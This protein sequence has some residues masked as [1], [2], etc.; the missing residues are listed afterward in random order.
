VNLLRP[1]QINTFESGNAQ[2]EELRALSLI[3]IYCAPRTFAAAMYN[4]L[5]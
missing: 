3:E 2:Q 4:N 1:V 5:G